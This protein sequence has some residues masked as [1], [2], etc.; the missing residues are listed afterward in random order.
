MTPFMVN[1]S[2]DRPNWTADVIRMQGSG[3]ACQRSSGSLGLDCQR[4]ENKLGQARDGEAG[5]DEP[6]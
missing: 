6:R 3:T 2:S 4:K 1:I 5:H